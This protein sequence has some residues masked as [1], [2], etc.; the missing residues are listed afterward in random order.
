MKKLQTK[1]TEEVCGMKT[2]RNCSRRKKDVEV[3][4]QKI[5]SKQN[6]LDNLVMK[7]NKV[8]NL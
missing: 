3:L 4:Y 8:I 7:L 1:T 5:K 6:E 2:E